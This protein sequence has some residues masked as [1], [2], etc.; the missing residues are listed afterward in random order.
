MLLK[1]Q[2]IN[3]NP[4]QADQMNRM[5]PLGGEN[6]KSSDKSDIMMMIGMGQVMPFLMMKEKG[7]DSAL[8][9]MVTMNSMTGGID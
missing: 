2:Q 3:H 5:L 7:E 4:F 8:R 6:Q 1:Q 9:M